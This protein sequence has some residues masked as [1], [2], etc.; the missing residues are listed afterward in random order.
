MLKILRDYIDKNS[1]KLVI[2]ITGEK[3]ISELSI[4]LSKLYKIYVVNDFKTIL[5]N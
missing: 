2:I 3:H 5:Y 1:E 4:N